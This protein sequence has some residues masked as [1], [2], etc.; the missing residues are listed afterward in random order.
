[1]TKRKFFGLR[2]EKMP[3]GHD[4]TEA[5]ACEGFAAGARA[6]TRPVPAPSK[7]LKKLVD[8]SGGTRYHA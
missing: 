5:P 2:D 7:K 1:M 4:E 6:L 8:C 3:I